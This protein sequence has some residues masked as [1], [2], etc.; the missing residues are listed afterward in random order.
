MLTRL[1]LTDVG[2]APHL[3]VDL[4][5][6]LNVLTGDNG[7]G[8]T[9]L[10][11]VA[12]FA[13]TWC[14]AGEEALPGPGARPDPH[15]SGSWLTSRI[16]TSFD[17][18]PGAIRVYEYGFH[19]GQQGWILGPHGGA[20]TGPSAKRMEESLFPADG[21]V[22]F[23][24]VDGSFALWDAFRNR[25]RVPDR[26]GPAPDLPAF[27]FDPV[28]VW[29]GLEADGRVLCNGLLRDWVYW[30]QTND[31]AWGWL[32]AALDTLSGDDAER[33]VAGKPRRV[34]IDDA[35]DLPTLDLPYGN[36]PLTHASAGIRRICAL[37]YVLVWAWREHRIAAGL[38]R[39]EPARQITVLFDE[40]EAHLHPAWQRR[41]LP[42]LLA[43]V[44]RLAPE[45]RVQV[46]AST[47]SPLVLASL[48]PEFDPDQDRLF[49]FDLDETKR[50]PEVVLSPV[51]W[52]RH[53]DASTWLTSEVFDL[54]SARS[55]PAE[56]ALQAAITAL[57]RHDVS[58]AEVRAIH[59]RLSA[60]LGE[61]EPFWARWIPFA[62]R[63][64]VTP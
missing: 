25:G 26:A 50:P 34:R 6:R 56:D 45:V 37:A 19:V 49:T 36:V 22:L 55:K 39:T 61:T 38:R 32:T 9:F 10:L 28:T 21:L 48:E 35:R 30:Q 42:A 43:V 60:V 13:L 11:D 64:G 24:R 57:R 52:R 3:E 8:K 54:R 20:W 51:A 2:P 33:L 41:I 5:A 63:R 27:R 15:P 4:A 23:A 16:V 40:V 7:L 14:W 12:W 53:G 17:D 1:E 47:H 58:D 29:N 46:V 31:E 59:A 18:G 62:E 44:N